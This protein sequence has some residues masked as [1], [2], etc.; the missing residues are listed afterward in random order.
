MNPYSRIKEELKKQGKSIVWLA[1]K[2]RISNQSLSRTLS[3]K[4][5]SLKKYVDICD[6]LEI[7]PFAFGSDERSQSFMKAQLREL[8]NENENFVTAFTFINLYELID[9]DVVDNLIETIRPGATSLKSTDISF[10]NETEP[11]IYNLKYLLF[12]KEQILKN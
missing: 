3:G 2:L 1:E 9:I 11:D 8:E 5:L 7:S 6:A 12:I 10:K 4:T